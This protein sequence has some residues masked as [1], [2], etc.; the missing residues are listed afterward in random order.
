[1]P[2]TAPLNMFALL[3]TL[4]YFVVAAAALLFNTIIFPLESMCDFVQISSCRAD[5]GEYVRD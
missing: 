2:A 4:P 3:P 5:P 1:M